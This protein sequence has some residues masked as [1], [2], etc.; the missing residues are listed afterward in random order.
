MMNQ[1]KTIKLQLSEWVDTTP[2]A[3][4]GGKLEISKSDDDGGILIKDGSETIYIEP[5]LIDEL[6]KVLKKHK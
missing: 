5:Q 6:I 2:I 3:K 4:I 1:I